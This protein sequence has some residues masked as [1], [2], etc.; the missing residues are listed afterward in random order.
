MAQSALWQIQSLRSF[1]IC[2][3]DGAGDKEK[4]RVGESHKRKRGP[5]RQKCLVLCLAVFQE[6]TFCFN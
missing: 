4:V 1:P 3:G 2:P 6:N 5:G